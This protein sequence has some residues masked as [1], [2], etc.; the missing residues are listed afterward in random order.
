M[1]NEPMTVG[2]RWICQVCWKSNHPQADACWHCK[3]G[4]GIQEA[5]VEQRRVAVA[6]KKEAPE[7][8]PDIVVALPVVI[9]RGYAKTWLRGGLGMI[10]LPII[11]GLGGVTDVTYLLFTGGLAAGLVVFGFL[12]G[13]VADGMRDRE[14]WAFLVGV[15]LAVVGAIGS[16]LAFEVFVPGLIN[17]TAVRWGS[18]LVFGGAGL[19]AI[20]GLV[21]M[22]LRREGRGS[23]DPVTDR[24]PDRA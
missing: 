21:L 19:A 18:I 9:F 12:A 5:E 6:T 1:R 3:T 15:A 22:Y 20:A 8:I 11:L 7:A 24:T 4:R 16:V 13:E 10:A 23:P 14:V 17:P 2:D